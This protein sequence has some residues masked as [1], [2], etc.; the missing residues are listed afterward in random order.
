VLSEDKTDPFYIEP[1]RF[2]GETGTAW[3]NMKDAV[4][5]LG[6]KIEKSSDSYLWATF[7]TKFW[8]FVDDLELRM[9]AGNKAIQV[10]SASR[11]GKGDMGMNRKRV[12]QLR[13][14]FEK[15]QKDDRGD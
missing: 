6:G 9:D 1:F 14:L 3:V 5:Q 15:N 12:E 2:S 10:R 4:I 7:R 13:V 11:V 8:H